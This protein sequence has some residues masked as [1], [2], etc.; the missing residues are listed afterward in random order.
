MDTENNVDYHL[1][2]NRAD[3]EKETNVDTNLENVC[4]KDNVGNGEAQSLK[5]DDNIEDSITD[6]DNVQDNTDNKINIT[7]TDSSSTTTMSDKHAGSVV[8][9]NMDNTSLCNLLLY[10]SDDDSNTETS[11]FESNDE[12]EEEDSQQGYNYLLI[13]YILFC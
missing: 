12:E 11:E 2:T 6:T 7:S 1:N 13:L 4:N 10:S 8:I 3:T 5:S 9:K